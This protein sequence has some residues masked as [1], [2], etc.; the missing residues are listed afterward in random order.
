MDLTASRIASNE[1]KNRTM[2]G[3]EYESDLGKEE[4]KLNQLCE[5]NTWEEKQAA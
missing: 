3:F 2:L 1:G 4:F 5:Q